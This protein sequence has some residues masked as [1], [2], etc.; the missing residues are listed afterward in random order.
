MNNIKL[1]FFIK[2]R[3]SYINTNCLELNLGHRVSSSKIFNKK[4][5]EG[6][7]DIHLGVKNSPQTYINCGVEGCYIYWS[8][9]LES[10]FR[11]P[12]KKVLYLS[13]KNN[14]F[15]PNYTNDKEDVID[16]LNDENKHSLLNFYNTFLENITYH[17]NI[18]YFCLEYLYYKRNNTFPNM[19]TEKIN[20]NGLLILDIDDV[21]TNV[22]NYEYIK[23]AINIANNYKIKIILLTARQF[24]LLFGEKNK[25]KISKINDILDNIEFDYCNNV[26]D[27]WYNPFTFMNNNIDI[28]AN[29]M[30]FYEVK[31]F[32]IEKVMNI[33]NINNNNVIFYDDSIV[34]LNACKKLNI[35]IRI[36]KRKIGFDINNLYQFKQFIIRTVKTNI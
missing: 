11:A 23:E 5:I 20:Y 8:L 35:H 12:T 15:I 13:K 17:K 27:V 2:R 28:K 18:R 9:F 19:N 34:N 16:K 26:I 31:C 1:F 25:Q 10:I 24:P 30:N 4:K 32:T 3:W 6:F 33:Y 22:I 14:V 29:S 21:L 36:V 7:Y